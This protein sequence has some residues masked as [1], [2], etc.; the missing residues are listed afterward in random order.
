MLPVTIQGLTLA[1]LSEKRRLPMVRSVPFK[2]TAAGPAMSL[3]KLA[4]KL[5]PSAMV[6]P[7]HFV[8]SVQLPPVAEVH[9]PSAAWTTQVE[10]AA[11]SVVRETEKIVER[12]VF[13]GLEA[14]S[15]SH[16]SDPGCA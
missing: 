12:F 2:L 9:V 7:D 14:G 4:V 6:P 3:V 8:V 16:E 13:M 11:R 1:P 5:A 10:A 15:D